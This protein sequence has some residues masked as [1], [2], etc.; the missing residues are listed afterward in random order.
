MKAILLC[1]MALFGSFLSGCSSSNGHYVPISNGNSVFLVDTQT[2]KMY[3]LPPQYREGTQ[4]QK[5]VP[6]K[7]KLVA[8]F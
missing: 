8:E 4:P 2:G 5:D 7:W 1:T 6:A 3:N